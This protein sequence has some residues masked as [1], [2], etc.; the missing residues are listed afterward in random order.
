MDKIK[1]K[2]FCKFSFCFVILYFCVFQNI[3][4]SLKMSVNITYKSLIFF[5]FYNTYIF[6]NIFSDLTI[7]STIPRTKL[8]QLKKM[9]R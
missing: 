2:I 8:K 6:Y 5:C 7:R 1:L 4:L 9:N 3:N